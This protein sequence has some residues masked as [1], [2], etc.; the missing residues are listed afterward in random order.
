[1]RRRVILVAGSLLAIAVLLYVSCPVYDF[2]RTKLIYHHFSRFIN[3]IY[4]NPNWGVNED[5]SALEEVPAADILG[6]K[7]LVAFVFG[8]SN[9]A[10]SVDTPYT[11]HN[12]VYNY[13]DGKIYKAR[14]PLLGASGEFGSV[15]TRFADKL[16]DQ[17][18]YDKVLLI[19]IARQGS[20]ILNW[21][22]DGKLSPILDKTLEQLK[23]DNIKITHM[24]FHQGEADSYF[25]MDYSDYKFMLSKIFQHVRSLTNDSIPIVVAQVSLITDPECHNPSFLLCYRTSPD[26]IKAQINIADPKKNIFQGPNTDIIVPYT[27]RY[28]PDRIHFSEEGANN[29]AAALVDTVEKIEMYKYYAH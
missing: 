3:T 27:M 12:K 7:T 4:K 28:P 10:N 5:A 18:I 8:Q 25:Q 15:W 24:F 21:G 1:M 16:I 2:V 19:N 22:A 6:D 11:P 20:S 29:F 14:D 13:Y 17:H 26:I 9:V 23:K